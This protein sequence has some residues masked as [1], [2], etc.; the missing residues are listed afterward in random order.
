MLPGQPAE[1]VW[2]RLEQ[3]R[4]RLGARGGDLPSWLGGVEPTLR[5]Q[6]RGDLGIGLDQ[7][8]RELRGLGGHGAES[9]AERQVRKGALAEIDAVTDDDPPAAVG[10]AGA[11]LAQQ[12]G[13]SDPGIAA[14]QHR[15]RG[16][17]GGDRRVGLDPDPEP[18][19]KLL[20]LRGPTDQW[21]SWCGTHGIHHCGSLEP[22]WEFRTAC[23]GH[24]G[25]AGRLLRPGRGRNPRVR[26]CASRRGVASRSPGCRAHT[27]TLPSPRIVPV[28]LV[29]GSTVRV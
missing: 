15:R 16:A 4:G 26:S 8:A 19:F 10:G 13:L 29:T 21:P 20:Q 22:P 11:Q 25:F 6:Q 12:P 24:R 9:V 28:F 27:S 3:P 14:E 1:G 5:G 17:V 2:H 23:S 7:R 18:A